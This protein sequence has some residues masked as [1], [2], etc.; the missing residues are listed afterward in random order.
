[1]VWTLSYEIDC[2][3]SRGKRPCWN[4]RELWYG[5]LSYEIHGMLSIRKE[6]LVLGNYGVDPK[7]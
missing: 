7:P 1:M 2:A 6:T 4:V 5:P 3:S